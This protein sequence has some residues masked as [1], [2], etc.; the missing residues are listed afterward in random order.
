MPHDKYYL[1]G[2]VQL[3]I[4]SDDL[5]GRVEPKVRMEGRAPRAIHQVMAWNPLP[6]TRP[7]GKVDYN[8]GSNQAYQ[9][10]E[11][12]KM[13]RATVAGSTQLSFQPLPSMLT[14]N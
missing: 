11:N 9:C 10:V 8:Q 1:F 12:I 5:P 7:N 2:K 14:A 6:F 3:Y 4:D 13:N